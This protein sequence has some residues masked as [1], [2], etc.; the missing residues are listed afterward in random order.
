M[1]PTPEVPPV[2]PTLE[3][4]P[5]PFERSLEIVKKARG[6]YDTESD[7]I[8]EIDK[9]SRPLYECINAVCTKYRVSWHPRDILDVLLELMP[10]QYKPFED[11]SYTDIKTR[12]E[13]GIESG[14][15]TQDKSDPTY[16]YMHR[17]IGKED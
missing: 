14:R 11:I 2:I 12:L 7:A 8:N 15:I 6:F 5:S 16:S 9:L 4:T 10:E 1:Q 13:E 17:I 3:S